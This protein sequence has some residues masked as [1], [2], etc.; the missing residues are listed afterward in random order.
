MRIF[1]EKTIPAK[2]SRELVSIRCDICTRQAKD[3][4]NWSGRSIYDIDGT[5]VRME[6]QRSDGTSFPEGTRRTDIR[7]DIC[8]TCFEEKLVPFLES[9]GAKPSTYEEP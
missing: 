3:P 8:P 9:L 4:E 5:T 2:T 1:A 7:F 6:I